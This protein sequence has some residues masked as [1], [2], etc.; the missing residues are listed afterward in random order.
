M[1]SRFAPLSALALLITCFAFNLVRCEYSYS[2]ESSDEERHKLKETVTHLHFYYFEIHTGQNPSAVAVARANGSQ[3]PS[4]AP[5]G[6]V[7]AIDNPL[8]SGPEE[9]STV[10]GNAQ[11]LYV[12]SSKSD[13]LSLVMYVDYAFTSGEFHGSSFSVVSRNPVTEPTREMAVV[14]GRGR[15]RMAR[16]FAEING[17]SMNETSGNGVVEYHVTLYHYHTPANFE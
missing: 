9:D 16:G 15:F 17:Y 1:E 11:G 13:K 8:R 10:I 2:Y 3:T 14:G 4:S 12:S 7:F 6:T 5:F